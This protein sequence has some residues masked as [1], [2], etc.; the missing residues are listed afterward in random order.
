MLKRKSKPPFSF[1]FDSAAG[2]NICGNCAILYKMKCKGGGRVYRQQDLTL[3]R[4]RLRR[5]W[6]ITAAIAAALVA[7][8]VLT[9]IA[10]LF[11][12]GYALLVTAVLIVIL[13]LYEVIGPLRAYRKYLVRALAGQGVPLSG[14]VSRVESAVCRRM[15]HDFYELYFR[16][17]DGPEDRKLYI[18]SRF[19][20]LFPPGKVLWLKVLDHT[21]INC[22]EG[23]WTSL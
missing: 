3:V 11:W 2:F 9:L 7:G 4:R 14:T 21:V 22:S 12:P 5:A 20:P 17:V 15:G 1:L 13:V 18:E 19:A 23:E 16:P 10:R 6:L 8:Y